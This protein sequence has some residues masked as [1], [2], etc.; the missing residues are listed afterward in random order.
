MKK[1]KKPAHGAG[2]PLTLGELVTLAYDI[3]P[4]RASAVKLL[5]VLLGGHPIR[6]R[7]NSGG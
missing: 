7:M 4:N 6:V 1:M 5:E 2:G 3:T